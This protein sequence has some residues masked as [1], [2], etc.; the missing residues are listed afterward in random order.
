LGFS[1]ETVVTVELSTGGDADGFKLTF[2]ENK[3]LVSGLYYWADWCVYEEIR[4]PK[5]ELELVDR[6]YYVSDWLASL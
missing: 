6:L 1:R 3:E 4:L 5:D 2:D